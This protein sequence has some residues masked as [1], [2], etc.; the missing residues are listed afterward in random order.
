MILQQLYKNIIVH[1]NKEERDV[2]K[3]YKKKYFV[4]IGHIIIIIKI[5][6]HYYIKFSLTHILRV[7]IIA[8]DN[9]KE[10]TAKT[11]CNTKYVC[12]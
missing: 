2:I 6:K 8:T 1:I 11:P 5:R 4:N 10:K 7:Y 12:T 3:I 9:W